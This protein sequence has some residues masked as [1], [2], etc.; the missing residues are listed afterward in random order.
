[1]IRDLL[2]IKSVLKVIMKFIKRRKVLPSK[3][4][5]SKKIKENSLKLNKINNKW[6]LDT[7]FSKR[8]VIRLVYLYKKEF[9]FIINRF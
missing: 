1:M 4:K 7:Q 3:L 5:K 2:F 8:A 9:K 6:S